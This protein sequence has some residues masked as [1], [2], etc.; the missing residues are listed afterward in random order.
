MSGGVDS[1]V[2]AYLLKKQGYDVDGVYMR[3]WDTSDERGVC[4]SEEDWKDVQRVCEQLSI[5]CRRV[6]FTKEY[7]TE[8]FERV[9]SDYAKGV[10]P[11]P[12]ILCNREIKFGALMDRALEGYGKWLA[13]GHYARVVQVDSQTRLFRGIDRNKDQSY[14]LANVG[15]SKLKQALFPLGELTKP[16][17]REI[18]VE[19]NL[20]TKHKAESMGICFV[21]KRKKFS[22]FL[23]EYIPQNP[24]E[25]VDVDGRLVGTHQGLFSLTI[26][27]CAKIAG[28]GER[29]F[30]LDK[31]IQ[32]NQIIVGPGRDHPKLYSNALIARDLFWINGEMPGD[33]LPVEA[34][35]RYRTDPERCKIVK[36]QGDQYQFTF[37]NSQR[38]VVP[39][40]YV[41][42]YQGD[43]C[44][45]GGVID[46]V[47]SS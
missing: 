5:P 18:A 43:W 16:Q 29:M 24:G 1:S 4:T 40:Q 33:K 25:I 28:R 36:I 15:E 32:R 41:V 20:A 17:V 2:T 37:E 23:A 9:L 22:D 34:Q 10:T 26:G 44:L 3:N 27:Q 19:A 35:I 47:F 12:D 31:D 11:N 14:Y 8:V 46:Q 21:G 38:G 42:V 7:W 6:D 30:V 45:G 39:G 13:T